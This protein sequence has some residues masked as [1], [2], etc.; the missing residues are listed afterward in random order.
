M[1]S[2]LPPTGSAPFAKKL[3]CVATAIA[4]VMLLLSFT[5]LLVINTLQRRTAE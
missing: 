2:I 4:V 5:L 3:L 1:E